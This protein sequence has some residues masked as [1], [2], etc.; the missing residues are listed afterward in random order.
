MALEYLP[1]FS[2]HKSPS[3]VGKDT[4]TMPYIGYMEHMGYGMKYSSLWI[5]GHCLRGRYLYI[6]NHAPVPL[7]FRR[8]RWIHRGHK[9]YPLVI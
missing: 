5:H 3:F 9:G 1:T 7:P 6:P 2:Q 8:Y 4:S